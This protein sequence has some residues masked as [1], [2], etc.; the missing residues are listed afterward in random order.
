MTDYIPYETIPFRLSI[1]QGDNLYISSDILEIAKICRCHGERFDC[2]VFIE[3]LQQSVGKEGTLLFPV[4][5]WGYCQGENFDYLKTKGKTGALGNAA[6]SI[7]GFYRTRHPIYSFAVWGQH[8][9]LLQSMNDT[10]SFGEN[11]PFGWLHRNSGKNLLIGVDMQRSFTFTHYVEHQE[12]VCYRYHKNFISTY[13]D[14]SQIKTTQSY[15]MYV[16]DL[17]LNVVMEQQPMQ[18]MLLQAGVCVNQSINGIDYLM[19]FLPKVYDIISEDIR[20]N[21]SKNICRYDGQ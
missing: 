3:A 2:T 6:L 20:H 10:E 5:N 4:F 18:E 17:S 14:E 7:P 8:A 13:T 9:E 21:R 1:N 11:S 19:L 15:S 16:R 12:K